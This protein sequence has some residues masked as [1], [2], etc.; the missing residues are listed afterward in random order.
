MG[1][2]CSTTDTYIHTHTHT[3]GIQAGKSGNKENKRSYRIILT[4][5]L[6]TIHKQ[7]LGWPHISFITHSLICGICFHNIAIWSPILEMIFLEH[8]VLEISLVPIDFN[9]PNSY[10]F[11]S[12]KAFSKANVNYKRI[13]KKKCPHIA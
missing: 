1:S 13:K 4:S 11:K 6:R 5:R 12:M 10:H 8:K 3:R 7:I 2:I 9:N